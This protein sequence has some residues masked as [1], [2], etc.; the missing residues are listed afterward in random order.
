MLK[1]M[2]Y[3]LPDQLDK[4]EEFKRYLRKD[5]SVLYWYA[6]YFTVSLPKPRT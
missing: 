2:S 1:M 4:D 3:Y 6:E 5:Q